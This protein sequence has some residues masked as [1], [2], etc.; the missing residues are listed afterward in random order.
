[1]QKLLAFTAIGVFAVFRMF[2]VVDRAARD[3]ILFTSP[4]P[5]IDHLAAL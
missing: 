4:S 5:Q 2:V 3:G 1:M